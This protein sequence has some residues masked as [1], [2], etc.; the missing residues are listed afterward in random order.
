MADILA[1]AHTTP[2]LVSE[3]PYPPS[4]DLSIHNPNSHTS[5]R[6]DDDDEEKW[7]WVLDPMTRK[8]RVPVHLLNPTQATATSGTV[9]SLCIAYLEGRCRHPWCRQAHV[10]P[11]AIPQ[12]RFEALNAPTCCHLHSDPHDIS[13][14]TNRFQYIRIVNNGPNGDSELIPTDRVASTVGLLRYL[15]HNVL[16]KKNTSDALVGKEKTE[17]DT[18]STT[19]TSSGSGPTETSGNGAPSEDGV[20]EL[21]AKFICRLHLAHRCRYLEDCNNIHLCREYELQLQ[22]PPHVLGALSGV[23]ASTRT[24]TVADACYTVTPLA[25]GDVSDEDFHAISEAQKAHHNRSENDDNSNNNNNNVGV[26]NGNSAMPWAVPTNPFDSAVRSATGN[27]PMLYAQGSA[28]TPLVVASGGKGSGSGLPPFPEYWQLPSALG[29]AAS[30]STATHPAGTFPAPCSAHLRVYDVRP[31]NSSSSHN[32]STSVNGGGSAS[33]IPNSM[34]NSGHNTVAPVDTS[35]AKPASAVTTSNSANKS[36]EGKSLASSTATTTAPGG[37][38]AARPAKHE[39]ALWGRTDTGA[40]IS[41]SGANTP[42]ADGGFA[43]F[44]HGVS[45]A[46]NLK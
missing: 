45:D 11:S 10:L 44:R 42:V 28:M 5:A 31:K 39:N 14:L 19:N 37:V 17:A 1:S 16:P 43:A 18:N 2:F 13:K 36:V 22:P 27:S 15:V 4:Q 7:I 23:T 21:P 25:V 35:C 29:S 24:V 46:V 40:S 33:S 41:T 38:T 9:P 32:G 12:L 6:N 30:V 34:P 3:V 20:L 8:L 26:S